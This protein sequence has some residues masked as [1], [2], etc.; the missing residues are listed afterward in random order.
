MSEWKNASRGMPGI[1]Q[2]L[3]AVILVLILSVGL[4]G[5]ESR[6]FCMYTKDAQ[7]WLY[8]LGG[9]SVEQLTND[10]LQVPEEYNPTNLEHGSITVNQLTTVDAHS[11]RM[12]YPTALVN[13]IYS[14]KYKNNGWDAEESEL[15]ASDI[16]KHWVGENA[17]R[18][19]YWTTS[20][21]LWRY[22]LDQSYELAKNVEA[23]F[24]TKKQLDVCYLVKDGVLYF[25]SGDT[26]AEEI[27]RNVDKL[28]GIDCNS[29]VYYR[30]QDLLYIKKVGEE[31]ENIAEHITA[32]A[33]DEDNGGCYIL[34][35]HDVDGNDIFD[36]DLGVNVLSKRMDRV[37]FYD[38]T[39]S[40]PL[41]YL[42]ISEE[43]LKQ[44]ED[45]EAY[46]VGQLMMG[47]GRVCFIG[48]GENEMEELC[49]ERLDREDIS[50]YQSKHGCTLDEA[51][52]AL[53]NTTLC[54]NIGYRI[55]VG[56]KL[57][58]RSWGLQEGFVPCM[59]S[60]GDVFYYIIQ[61]ENGAS[62]HSLSLGE[63]PM[64]KKVAAN[65]A[66]ETLRFFSSGTRPVYLIKTRQA[67]TSDGK[68][69]GS[70]G[71]LWISE[72]KVANEAYSYRI[73]YDEE[74]DTLYFLTEYDMDTEMGVLLRYSKGRNT[75][76]A[77]DVYY[78]TITTNGELVYLKNYDMV[79]CKGELYLYQDGG[80]I[81]LDT[82]VANIIQ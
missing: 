68:L 23:C 72:E 69:E 14:L 75:E 58:N 28:Y 29:A 66:P 36:T 31:A 61:G 5:C 60:G 26:K 81:L 74:G 3:L 50:K 76:I 59:E 13:G 52:Q 33:L 73:W 43:K 49:S 65:I 22:D 57:I 82:E 6:G 41:G 44:A 16:V 24:G 18:L 2:H 10:F 30:K 20:S 17:Q 34:T 79:R 77:S 54:D 67:I 37:R 27:D 62:L 53:W 19:I 71:E 42:E 55:A 21:E 48:L 40:H 25:Q 46:L 64:D 4:L 15:I 8:H 7:I 47:N 51:V 80:E 38:G 1:M 56:S 9:G 11:L 45:A 32:V 12:F 78:Y 63:V 39:R 70:F 35:A